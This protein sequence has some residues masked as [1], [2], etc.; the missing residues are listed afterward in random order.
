M[1]QDNPYQA[2]AADL[3][4]PALLGGRPLLSAGLTGDATEDELRVFVGRR[5]G[6]YLKKWRR[7]LAGQ[8]GAGFN[9]AAFLFTGFWLPYR[10]LYR[11]T[12][13][14]Y[15]IGFAETLAEEVVFRFVLGTGEPP[16]PLSSVFGLVVALVGG[17]G[18][19]AWYLRRARRVIAETRA[20]GLPDDEYTDRL[21]RR[22]GTNLPAA[23]GLFLA[24]IAAMSALAVVFEPTLFA[25]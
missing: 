1:D 25:D 14:F 24:F 2:P 19:N 5:A 16:A 6:Y 12:A 13:L 22:G 3:T 11:A 4:D 7:A 21:A 15:G 20:L 10:K 17:A 9:W 23:L 8:G 18:G